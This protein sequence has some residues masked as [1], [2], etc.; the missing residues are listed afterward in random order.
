MNNYQFKNLYGTVYRK[1]N[2]CF[3]R[4]G[5][6]LL[7]PVGNKISFYNLE[8]GKSRTLDYNFRFDVSFMALDPSPSSK[9]LFVATSNGDLHVCS[10]EKNVVLHRETTDR[11]IL[12]AKFSPDGKFIAVSKEDT[13][14][15][16]YEAE[17]FKQPRFGPLGLH[18]VLQGQMSSVTKLAWSDNSEWIASG[19]DS[20]RIYSLLS[21]KVYC[22][23]SGSEVVHIAFTDTSPLSCHTLNSSGHLNQWEISEETEKFTRSSR[24]FIKDF[25][26]DKNMAFEVTSADYHPCMDILVAGYSE[27]SF[28][29]LQL[30]DVS[31]IHSLN[32]NTCISTININCSGD[33]IALGSS[34]AGSLLVWEWKS[35]TYIMKQKGHYNNLESLS[36]SRDGIMVATGGSD[37]KVKVWNSSSGFCFVTFSEHSSPVSGVAFTSNNKALISS[38]LDGTVRAFDLI[39][40]RNFRTF[41]SP[42]PVQFACVAVDATGE[43]IAAGAKDVF[44]IYLWSLKTG[45]LLEVISGH[46]GPVNSLSFSPSITSSS[47]LVSASWD[48]TMR[49]WNSLESNSTSSE[50]INLGSDGIAVAFRPDGLEVAVATLNGQLSIFDLKT[51]N[52]IGT[53]EGKDDLGAGRADSDLITASKSKESQYFRTLAYSTNGKF[54][55]AGGSSKFICL[56]HVKESLLVKK[57]EI[58][59]NRDLDAM[60]DVI[61][62]KSASEFGNLAL[63]ED[64]G[65]DDVMQLPGARKDEKSARSVHPEIKVTD[66]Q[67]A[68]TGREFAITTTEGLLVYSLDVDTVFDPTDLEIDITPSYVI[69][70]LNRK[71]YSTALFG[72]LKLNETKLI[73]QV[74]E[75]IPFESSVF[76]LETFPDKY[77]NQLLT[78]FGK[79]LETSRHLEFYS[80]WIQSFFRFK[81]GSLIKKNG[82]ELYPC[83]NLLQKSLLVRSKDLA[84]LC[85][86]NSYTA[87][88][89]LA[90][91]KI[92]RKKNLSIMEKDDGSESMEENEFELDD[93]VM[94]GD[95]QFVSNWD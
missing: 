32:M 12:D 57:F 45:R 74:I 94:G 68:P 18:K 37:G 66:A 43:L 86:Q 47:T 33:W 81:G 28:V 51:G 17:T 29:V 54:I 14:T 71:Q 19:S 87:S 22:L 91:G 34:S 20:T 41:A 50:V 16:I 39:R 56:Y 23:G 48:Q 13:S 80:L 70:Q 65:D 30:P 93:I 3:S 82:K 92:K 21:D 6:T 10:L 8:H 58:T 26:Q 25:L 1:G 90:M 31:L 67:F 95:E 38:S 84:Q 5:G 4:D 40:Y 85:D 44:D 59:Q 9:T 69:Q 78:F 73:R 11:R 64:R 89:L 52:Q 75:T 46:E 55:I 36:Y 61:S 76:I 7:S 53:I 79:E 42:K 83:L 2:L 35:E 88:F 63:V 15:L 49:I 27:G 60:D 72:S 77:V 24:H 62:R